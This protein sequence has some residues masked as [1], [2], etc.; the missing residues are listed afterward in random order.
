MSSQLPGGLALLYS[1]LAL[2]RGGV[3]ADRRIVEALADDED[4]RAGAPL[5]ELAALLKLSPS[6]ADA[7]SHLPAVFSP[8]T[9]ALL[10]DAEAQ[11][12][13]AGA[14]ELLARDS[15]W[16][17]RREREL[18]R[19]LSYPVLLLMGVCALLLL[20]STLVIPSFQ[21]VLQSFGGDLPGVTLLV[22]WMAPFLTTVVLGV[23][24]LLVLQRVL[25][26]RWFDRLRGGI[27]A[28]FSRLPR[29][30]RYRHSGVEPRILSAMAL[31][32]RHGLP[33]ADVAAHLR[34]TTSRGLEAQVLGA[35]EAQ[36]AR[37]LPLG[38]ACQ[39]VPELPRRLGLLAT[40]AEARDQGADALERL[41]EVAADHSLEQRERLHR[42]ATVVAYSVAAVIVALCIVALYLPIFKLG[43]V[44]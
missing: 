35:L 33:L 40:D 38:A 27:T 14:L 11:G 39:A 3:D 9:V 8:A 29:W 24:A 23:L 10:R 31:A 16:L 26:L 32:L 21:E 20:M 42:S 34:A 37:G 7:M 15:L 43:S 5:R 19:G 1:Q 4:A 2:H 17:D 22:L 30:R 25:Q 28:L 36:L 12:R 41:A 18:W 6:L 44:S 13:G